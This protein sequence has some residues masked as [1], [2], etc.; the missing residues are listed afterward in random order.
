WPA[1]S[2][3]KTVGKPLGHGQCKS[4]VKRIA[5]GSL[6]VHVAPRHLHSTRKACRKSAGLRQ[7]NQIGVTA[8]QPRESWIRTGRPEE[9][10]RSRGA[11]RADGRAASRRRTTEPESP[12]GFDPHAPGA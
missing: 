7:A 12:G 1:R 11:D 3:F 2:Q 6:R 8:H 4:V 9:I 5:R 10:K